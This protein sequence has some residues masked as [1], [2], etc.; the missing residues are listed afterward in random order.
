[1]FRMAPLLVLRTASKHTCRA[2]Q[3]PACTVES[4]SNVRE[5]TS[6]GVACL[7][8]PWTMLPAW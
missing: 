5:K 2:S 8:Q 4:L 6:A 1:M 7:T 3:H